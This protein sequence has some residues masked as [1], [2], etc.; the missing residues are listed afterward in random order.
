MIANWRIDWNLGDFP[1][2]FVQITPHRGQNPEI[3]ESQL[4]S[5]RTV[6]NTGIVVTTDI[7]DSANI[8]PINKQTV[9]YRLALWAL[10]HNYGQ[11]NLVFSGP[12]YKNY[13]I[14]G[15]KIRILF[16]FV[17]SGLHSNNEVLKGFTIC[18]ED[19]NFVPANAKIEGNSVVVWDERVKNP[20]SVHFGWVNVPDL[21]LFNKEGLPASPFRTD[22]WPEKTYAK[23]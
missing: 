2:Y 18:G 1:F 8:H 7:G 6:P 20:V 3:R 19:K 11:R 4:Y 14:E 23:N 13:K 21:N 22:D 12:L 5:Y 9:G 17:G 10:A 16:D 15:D